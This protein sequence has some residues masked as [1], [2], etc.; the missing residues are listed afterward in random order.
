[1]KGP[2]VEDRWTRRDPETGKR[3]P[4]ASHGKGS[5]WRA[6]YFMPDGTEVNRRF[7][8]KV[9]AE[10]WLAE[11]S[12]GL[13]R[14]DHVDDRRGRVTFADWSATWLA[15][16]SDLKPST[17]AR[18]A[19]ILEVHLVPRFGPAEIGSLTHAEVAAFVA[20]LLAG[21]GGRRPLSASSVRQIH[22]T[23]SLVLAFAVRDGRLVRNV[24][25]GVPL[26]RAAKPDKRH[27]SLAQLRDLA[28]AAGEDGRLVVMLLGLTGL[29]FGELVALRVGRVDLMRRRIE[30]A[31]SASEV[32][33]HLTFGTPKTHQ[34]RTVPVPRSLVDDLAEVMAG[35]APT[36]LVFT[37]R[38]GTPLRLMN[39][40]HRT[41][42]PAVR[43]VGLDGLTPHELRHT[44]ASLAV[45]SGAGLKAVQ[46]LLGHASAAMTA[47]V[48]AHL[49]EDELDGLTDRMD[50]ALAALPEPPSAAVLEVAR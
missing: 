11:Q 28:D 21:A 47:D 48:Y 1:M 43:A 2:S 26:P 5:R 29:R 45:A 9:D 37:T 38:V 34:R 4:S 42:D 30:V 3:V 35:K 16:K 19:S 36:E 25:E 44:A 7:A 22:R 15:A 18:Y 46:R 27:L 49:F 17:R 23:L 13:V 41:F 6:R 24:A 31:E 32:G 12:A 8:R 40:R 10:R 39:W 20:D 14:G 33:G 50:A